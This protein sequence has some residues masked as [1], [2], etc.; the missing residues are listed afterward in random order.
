MARKV[1]IR[2]QRKPHTVV[3]GAG[4]TEFWYLKHLKKLQG[5]RYVLR[6]SLFG[7]ESMPAIQQRIQDAIT[8]GSSVICV[9]DEDV[10][11]WN[12]TEKKRMADIHRMYD[13]HD[14]VVIASSMPS[15]EY[16]FLLHYEN[17]N[18]FF[19]TSEKVMEA[20]RKH[21]LNFDKKEQFLKQEKW[22]ASMIEEDRMTAA[23]ER[24]KQPNHSSPSFSNMWKAIDRMKH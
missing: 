20:L 1:S 12:D 19:G 10:R 14:K 2:E 5:F 8:S 9:F 24:A 3:V 17:T 23:Y 21:I 16:W 4:I 15:I 13:G 7:N 11:Q 22:V 6:P 18:R